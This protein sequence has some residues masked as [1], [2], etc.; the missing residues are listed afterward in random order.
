M[1]NALALRQQYEKITGAYAKAGR[2]PVTTASTL[3]LM[4]PVVANKT[5]YSFPIIQGDAITNFNEQILLDRADAFTALSVGIFFGGVQDGG[6]ASTTYNYQLMGYQSQGLTTAGIT[7]ANC[8]FQ[9]STLNVAVNNVK[10]LQNWDI[11][12]CFTAPIAQTGNLLATGTSTTLQNSINGETDGFAP[13]IPTLQFSGTSKIDI[14]INL[15]Y[16]LAFGSVA[17]QINVIFRGFLSLG[18]SNLNR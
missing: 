18:A 13:L 1:S 15:P 9:H 6:T 7:N 16:A 11:F 3:R 4:T 12:Q 14:T 2:K 17:T 10:Y 8:L 5:T